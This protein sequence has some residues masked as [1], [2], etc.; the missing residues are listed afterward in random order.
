MKLPKNSTGKF[1]QYK[2]NFPDEFMEQSRF[3]LG[4]ITAEG[5]K[6]AH[7][8]YYNEK[9]QKKLSGFDAEDIV[10]FDIESHKFSRTQYLFLDFDHILNDGKFVNEKVALF[11]RNLLLTFPKIY[12]EYSVSYTGLHAFLKPDPDKFDS[13]TPAKFYFS[14][15]TK[16]DAPQLEIFFKTNGRGCLLTGKKYGNSGRMIPANKINENGIYEPEVDNFLNNL[17]AE[18]KT[19]QDN[20]NKTKKSAPK[21]EKGNAS[22]RENKHYNTPPEYRR[23]LSIACA[24][25]CNFADLPNPEWLPYFIALVNEGFTL[26]ELRGYCEHSPRYNAKEFDAQYKWALNKP[27][28][29]VKTLIGKAQQAGFIVKDFYKKWCIEHHSQAFDDFDDLSLTKEEEILFWEQEREQIDAQFV[30]FDKE[31]NA[32]ISKI[33]DIIKNKKSFDKDFVFAEDIVKA[34]AF[35]SKFDPVIFTKF[36]SAIQI[37]AK[38]QN[39]SFISDWNKQIKLAV[40][41]IE[42][43]YSQ[44]QAKRKNILAKIDSLHF[45]VENDLLKNLECPDSYRIANDG[46][47]KICGEKS[48]PV[49]PRPIAILNEVLDTETHFTKW[50]LAY[51]SNTGH[52]VKIPAQDAETISKPFKIPVLSRHKFPVNGVNAARVVE[53]LSDFSWANENKFPLIHTVP[54]CG[55]H[56]YRNNKYFIDPRWEI[57]A[58]DNYGKEIKI[59]VDTDKCILAKSLSC[60]GNL[61]QWKNAYNLAIVSPFARLAVAASVAPALLEIIGERNFILYTHGATHSG[62]S[63]IMYLSASAVGKSEKLVR[64]FDGSPTALTALTAE[65]TDYTTFIDERQAGSKDPKEILS[66]VYSLANGMEKTRAAVDGKIR[67]SRE[68]QTIAFLNGE[69]DLLPD[70]AT[71]GAWTRT[72]SISTPRIILDED[73]C[74][75]IREIIK[76][77]FGVVFPKV[78]EK[79]FE[80]GFD[81]IKENYNRIVST[82][83]NKFSNI[84]S[85]HRRYLAVLTLADTLLNM[86]L[87]VNE[88]DAYKDALDNAYKIVDSI[89]TQAEI[90]DTKGEKDFVMSFIAQNQNNFITGNL[91][92]DKIKTVLGKIADDYIFILAS[93]LKQNCETAG[94]NYKKLVRDLIENNFFVPDDKIERD[95]KKPRPTVKQRLNETNAYCLRIPK[96]YLTE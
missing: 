83:A 2:N 95:R 82:F 1:T 65:N 4:K 69:V 25:F 55:W 26:E 37:Q 29:G 73:T 17:L 16:K 71:G 48:I 72:L 54:S 53:F 66:L 36:K 45:F 35:C 23:D 13:L 42:K 93:A 87:G 96:K 77:N 76:T 43:R 5:I 62:K 31:K 67:E 51:K 18:I 81:S 3:Y 78:I 27:T 34:A 79:I 46:I 88:N 30:D 20:D 85:E 14:D 90:D 22:S 57:S 75:S 50:I 40:Q 12:I 11:V 39:E 15:N 94:Y 56:E 64:T 44:L 89:P 74:K 59:I 8:D 60:N 19:Q 7:K 41:N 52:W 86:V 24:L 91:N 61:D 28:F 63:T 58:T 68:W 38:M 80:I 33:Q 70:S 9:N 10:F 47:E 21:K 6:P 92:D 84:L 49:C 32:A